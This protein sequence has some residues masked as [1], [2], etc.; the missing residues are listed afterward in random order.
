MKDKTTISLTQ[1]V[2]KKLELLNIDK[3]EWNAFFLFLIK[4]LKTYKYRTERYKSDNIKLRL[5]IQVL[6]EKLPYY[7]EENEDKCEMFD[8]F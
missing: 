4:E 5:Q 6:M 3:L 1:A 7:E 8:I 2:K